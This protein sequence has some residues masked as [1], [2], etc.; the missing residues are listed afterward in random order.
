MVKQLLDISKAYV[1]R[2]PSFGVLRHQLTFP[3]CQCRC[4]KVYANLDETF[5]TVAGPP[6]SAIFIVVNQIGSI[7][8]HILVH[9]PPSS[10]AIVT[11]M[12]RYSGAFLSVESAYTPASHLHER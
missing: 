9:I 2:A 8:S 1:P 12:P 11:L 3:H 5:A 4:V 6:R 7:C 10:P